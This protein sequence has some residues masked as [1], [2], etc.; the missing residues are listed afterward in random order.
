MTSR[1]VSQYVRYVLRPL[2]DQGP[3][4]RTIC[5]AGA[6]Q[7]TIRSRPGTSARAEDILQ[8]I[9]RKAVSDFKSELS[10][11]QFRK[12][13]RINGPDQ[14]VEELSSS[15]SAYLDHRIPRLF[16]KLD[17]L[18]QQ[19]KFFTQSISI[20]V[21]SHPQFAALVWGSICVLLQGRR[22]LRLPLPF[23]VI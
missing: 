5:R 19:L 21:S 8:D 2:Q 7:N 16:Q 4:V 15:N 14:L 23:P 6:D 13:E 1:W 12:L 9:W 22:F 17:P 3:P 11:E 18:L 10:P 20:L